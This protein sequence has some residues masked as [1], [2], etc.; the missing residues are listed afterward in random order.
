MCVLSR[1]CQVQLFVTLQ[2]IAARI[3][4]PWDSPGK[5]TRVGCHGLLQRILNS[6]LLRLLHWQVGSLPLA[7]PGKPLFSLQ[8]LINCSF[9]QTVELHCAH[10]KTDA[11]S[12]TRGNSMQ[13]P[14]VRSFQSSLMSNT[15]STN[16][17]HISL[18][19]P[20]AS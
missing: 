3:L 9:S 7:P 5:N 12:K 8:I 10:V 15:R 4:C 6:R 16:S 13:I 1:F 19:E 20:W 11:Q 17:S 14:R 18:L 2:T